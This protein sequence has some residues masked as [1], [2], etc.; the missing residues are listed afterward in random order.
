MALATNGSAEPECRCC[1]FEKMDAYGSMRNAD[2][3][4]DDVIYPGI[5]VICR[6]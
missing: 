2:K 5:G 3:A 6:R 1:C 4:L